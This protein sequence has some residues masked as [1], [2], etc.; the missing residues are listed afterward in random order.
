MWQRLWQKSFGAST[1]AVQDRKWLQWLLAAGAS[2]LILATWPLWWCTTDFPQVP[3]FAWGCDVPI[4]VDRIL[5]LILIGSLASLFFSTAGGP[6]SRAGLLTFAIAALGLVLLNQQR[7]QP[8]MYQ[9]ILV[10]LVLASTNFKQAFALLR[11]LNVSIYF[12]SGVSKLDLSFSYGLGQQF[13]QAARGLMRMDPSSSG[14]V[15]HIAAG[16][17]AFGA[18]PLLF[19]IGE[20]VIALALIYP[21]TRRVAVWAACAM[22]L[23]LLLILGPFGLNH[24]YGVLIWNVVFM[25]L[26]VILF[27]PFRVPES[28]LTSSSQANPEVVEKLVNRSGSVFASL[29]IG[30][31]VIWPCFEP[32]GG[33][34]TWLAWGLYA[35]HGEELTIEVSESGIEKLPPLWKGRLGT[36][37]IH[38]H[39][40]PDDEIVVRRVLHPKDVSLNV[41]KAPV[42]PSNRFL[43]AVALHIAATADLKDDEISGLWLFPA[44]RWTGFRRTRELAT[45]TEIQRAADGCWWN[46]RPRKA[47]K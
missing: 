25:L 6:G 12:Y 4:I 2:S 8:W 38:R 22:H 1:P 29:L 10:A 31:A 3:W 21:R 36:S 47:S 16:T 42:Y 13:F 11:L 19:P 14:L 18:W 27:A 5:L 32:L 39:S 37:L 15:K 46:A 26:N 44:N 33:C 43:L 9:F 28:N 30:W 45:L 20:I 24:Q 23:L 41:L 7:T 17:P 35:D 40:E 34:D